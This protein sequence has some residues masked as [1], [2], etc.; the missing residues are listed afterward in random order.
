M[1]KI[2]NLIYKN[3]SN[4]TLMSFNSEL[5]IN[6]NNAIKCSLKQN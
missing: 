4:N 3:S 5:I 2:K 1:Y 6:Y